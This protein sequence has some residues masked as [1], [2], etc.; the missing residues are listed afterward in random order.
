MYMWFRSRSFQTE[1][2]R[3]SAI[4]TRRQQKHL[5]W[6]LQLAKEKNA[7]L[8]LATDPDADRLGVH[9][10]D[11]KTGEYHSLTGNM[12]GCLL[13]EYDNQPD[14]GTEGTA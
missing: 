7:D 12:S 5:N 8:V 13:A 14:K 1:S 3:L 10:K 9:V 2:S 4:Q 6:H 11:A